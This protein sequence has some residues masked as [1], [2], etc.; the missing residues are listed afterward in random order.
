T[1]EAERCDVFGCQMLE[2]KL[3]VGFTDGR[4]DV[5]RSKCR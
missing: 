2:V 3:R 5:A 1:V 4:H